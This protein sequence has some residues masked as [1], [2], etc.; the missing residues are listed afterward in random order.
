M[1]IYVTDTRSSADDDKS[2]LHV[3]RSVKVTK[4]GTIRFVKYGFLLVCYSNFVR[5][6]YRFWDIW[7]QKYCDLENWV[8]GQSRSLEISPFDKRIWL[9]IDVL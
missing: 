1:L 9:S 5:K 6:M 8:K 3:Y 2:A 4:Y 7:L